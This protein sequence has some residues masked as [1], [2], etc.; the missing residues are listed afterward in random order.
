MAKLCRLRQPMLVQL[1]D[2]QAERHE[3]RLDGFGL[4]DSDLV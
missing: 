2:F 4:I 1:H 3:A